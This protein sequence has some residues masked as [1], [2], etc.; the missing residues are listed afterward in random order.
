MNWVKGTMFHQLCES[1]Q[2]QILCAMIDLRSVS[3]RNATKYPRNA[4]ISS[5]KYYWNRIDCT[6][7]SDPEAR[8]STNIL[9]QFDIHISRER[10]INNLFSVC[11]TNST[12]GEMKI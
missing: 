6:T 1:S 2:F 3:P 7:F 9:R 5:F 12:E 4:R 11:E 10:K 8:H